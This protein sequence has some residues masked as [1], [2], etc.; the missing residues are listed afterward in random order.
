AR[1]LANDKPFD[2][3]LARFEVFG[4]DAV[5]TDE[6]ISHADDLPAIRRIG[7]HFLVAGHA[8]IENDLAKRLAGSAEMAAGIDGPV[9]KGQF[10]GGHANLPLV[11]GSRALY[12]PTN[13]WIIFQREDLAATGRGDRYAVKL[14]P[15]LKIIGFRFISFRRHPFSTKNE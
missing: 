5:I 10:G 7:E 12:Q 11:A 1:Q 4:I 13:A 2:M 8:R 6:R 3:R 14:R 15:S 9:L